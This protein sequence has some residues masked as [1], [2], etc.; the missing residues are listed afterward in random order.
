MRWWCCARCP[1][2][3]RAEPVAREPLGRAGGLVTLGALLL[4]LSRAVVLFVLHPWVLADADGH[5]PV[6]EFV[7]TEFGRAS[8]VGI[9]L[10]L[11]LAAVA[12]RLRRRPTA[13]GPG[14]PPPPSRC[15]SSPTPPGSPTR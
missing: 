2:R 15:W 6:V 1:R 14:W 7:A 11:A 12:A 9:A 4:A 3:S 10:A 8:L 13:R 5:W